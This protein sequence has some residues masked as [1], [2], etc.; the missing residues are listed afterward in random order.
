M[1]EEHGRNGTP[2]ILYLILMGL[3]SPALLFLAS[4]DLRWAEGWGYSVFGF[5][6]SVVGRLALFK[7]SP[8]LAEERAKGLSRAGVEPWDR[9]IV[10]W[11]GLILPTLM[12]IAA[13]LDRRLGGAPHFPVWARAVAAVIVVAGALLGL[14]AALTNPF[15]SSVA[16]IQTERGQ[17]VVSDGPYRL[18]RHPGYAGTIAFNLLTPIVLGSSWAFVAA[19]PLIVLTVIRTRFEDRLLCEKLEGY[20]DYAAKVRFRLLPGI[21]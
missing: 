4:G 17:R 21:W 12:M 15:F 18:V 19:A 16:R 14:G 5:V 3:F 10:P 20:R 11:I 2:L 7:K 1:T 8:G 9:R 6:Y 13:G